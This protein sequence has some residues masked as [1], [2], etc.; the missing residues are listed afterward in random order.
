MIQDDPQIDQTKSTI[1]AGQEL[2]FLGQARKLQTS[3]SSFKYVPSDTIGVSKVVATRTGYM[4]VKST[5]LQATKKQ[6][7]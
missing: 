6:K 1:Q 4:D 2:S 7:N 3:T 5:N